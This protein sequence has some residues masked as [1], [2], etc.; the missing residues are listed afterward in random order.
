M[1]VIWNDVPC[2]EIHPIE[3]TS[4]IEKIAVTKGILDY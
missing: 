4:N 2:G 1:N 3:E